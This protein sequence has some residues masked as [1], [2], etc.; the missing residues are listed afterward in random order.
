MRGGELAQQPLGLRCQLNEHL[1][2]IIDIAV[3]ARKPPCR[4]PVHQPHGAVVADAQTLGQ[5]PSA[6]G[7]R[8]TEALDRQHGL[9]LLGG[10]SLDSR[11][12][13]AECEKSPQ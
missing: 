8:T 9:M 10:E 2:A 5:L 7:A 6:E 11:R 12:I 4:E 3:T 1:T 13:L